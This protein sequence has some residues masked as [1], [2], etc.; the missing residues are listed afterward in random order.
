MHKRA[1]IR[2]YDWRQ[3]EVLTDGG[4]SDQLEKSGKTMSFDLRRV[5]SYIHLYH[6][7]FLLYG[8]ITSAW[9]A[10]KEKGLL[11]SICK[12][13]ILFFVKSFLSH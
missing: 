4:K 7:T 13:L 2:V 12:S 9:N 11:D 8:S 3:H 1:F 5:L 10:F 6:M